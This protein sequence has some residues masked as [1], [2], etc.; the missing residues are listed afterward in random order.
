MVEVLVALALVGLAG[1]VFL[2]SLNTVSTST[3]GAD[4]RATA[5]SL[6]SSQMEYVMNQSYDDSPGQ[7]DYDLITDI[8]AGWAI[9]VTAER[10]DPENDG[11]GD[12]DGIQEIT[13]TVTF[14]SEP[15]IVLTTRKVNLD[16]G[17]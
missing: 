10:L 17:F 5:D 9:E 2:S 3:L 8:P 14:E 13:T 1:M 11:Q 6:A 16:Y 12:D 15:V 7:P 4:T